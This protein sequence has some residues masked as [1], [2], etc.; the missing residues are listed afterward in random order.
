MRYMEE[1]NVLI[2]WTCTGPDITKP[3]Q[4]R[5]VPTGRAS[6]VWLEKN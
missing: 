5:A 4:H 3:L 1:G 2:N 6:S